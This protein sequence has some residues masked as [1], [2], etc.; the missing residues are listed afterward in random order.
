MFQV[1]DEMAK[2]DEGTL[3]CSAT[4]NTAERRRSLWYATQYPTD[5]R[6]VMHRAI[7]LDLHLVFCICVLLLNVGFNTSGQLTL[8]LTYRHNM[9]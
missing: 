9:F 2:E 4:Q 3:D 6:K 8:L 7:A 1:Q 5:E